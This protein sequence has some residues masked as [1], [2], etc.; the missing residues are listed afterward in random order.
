MDADDLDLDTPLDREEYKDDNE[1][2][3]FLGAYVLKCDLPG[4]VMPA[5]HFTSECHTA[6]MF[7]KAMRAAD[8]EGSK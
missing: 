4:C 3:G 1:E 6:E 8:G 2:G 7:E 5:Y